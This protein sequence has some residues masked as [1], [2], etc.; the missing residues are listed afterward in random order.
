MPWWRRSPALACAAGLAVLWAVFF[1]PALDPGG[2]FLFRDAGR[3]HWPMKAWLAQELSRGHLPEWNPFAGVGVPVIATGVDAPLH[4]FSLLLV[5]LPL[6]A[7]FKAWVLL[8]VLAAGLGAAAWA[9]RLGASWAGAAL[10]GAAFML[11][12]FVVS[13]TDNLTYL[14]TLAAAPWL[15]AAAHAFGAAGGPGRLA[16][17]GVASFLCAAAGDP[18]GWGVAAGLA[19]L[20]A[21]SAA[22]AGARPRRALLLGLACVAAAAPAV[23]PVVLWAPHSS[24]AGALS[25]AE[26]RSWNLA[27]ARLLELVVPHV[28]RGPLGEVYDAVYEA[29][30]PDDARMR[31]WVLSVHLGAPVA[32]LAALGASRARAVRWLVAGAAIAAWVAMGHHAGFGAI[33]RALPVLD[34]LRYWEKVAVWPALLLGAAAALGATA[35]A[36]DAGAARRLARGAGVGAVALVVLAAAAAVGPQAVG[37]FLGPGARGPGVRAEIAANI[38]EGA[39]HSAVALLALAAVAWSV[40]R[41][42]IVLAGPALIAAVVALDVGIASRDAWVLSPAAVVDGASPL[43]AAARGEGPS[44]RVVTPFMLPGEPVPGLRGFESR[45]RAGSRLLVDAWNVPAGIGN[46]DAYTGM[47]PAR[48]SRARE[49]LGRRELARRAG[50]WGFSLAA[51]PAVAEAVAQLGLPPPLQVAGVD[52]ETPAWLVR[53]PSRPR[54]YVAGEVASVDADG[55]LAFSRAEPVGSARSVVEGPVPPVHARGGEARVVADEPERVAVGVAVPGDL[56]GLLVLSDQQAPGW[57]ADVDGAPA[58]ILRANDLVRGVWVPGGAHLVTF[59]YRTPGL[60]E[61]VAVAAGLAAALAAWAVARRRVLDS[62]RTAPGTA[63]RAR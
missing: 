38:A 52:P 22:P 8:S 37:G 42:W 36:S 19:A 35:A 44:P 13:S 45:W 2:Q 27:P 51:T 55:A 31:P 46:F 61:G 7:A 62:S 33:A 6:G 21:Y 57:S 26:L 12:G 20:Q 30:A 47:A 29:M 3:M 24:R 4:P 25:E 39:V 5:A 16:L 9:R 48:L 34:R 40:A 49:A 50:L 11:S 60:V 43:V 32:A 18:M 17:A 1:A 56:P 10:A 28:S 41:G 15:L 23:L 63:G 14:T 53:I 54:A 59:R 58:E